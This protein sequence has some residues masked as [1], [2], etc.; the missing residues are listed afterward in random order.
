MNSETGCYT[1][2]EIWDTIVTCAH[3]T[4]EPG[5]CFIDRV[6]KDNPTPHIGRIEATNPCGEQPLLDYEACNLGSVNI[7]KFV[8]EKQTD[9]DWQLLKETVKLAIRFL[10]NVVDANF[11]PI[12]QIRCNTLGNRKIGLGIMDFADALILCLISSSSKL[13]P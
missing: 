11:Y 4:G 8:S 2:K 1:V 12:E 5:V 7:A 3:A 9:L 6:N 10:D 13:F